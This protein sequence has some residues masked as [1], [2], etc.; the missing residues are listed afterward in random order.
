MTSKENKE[1]EEEKKHNQMS[2]AFMCAI[3]AIIGILYVVVKVLFIHGHCWVDF[4]LLILLLF[5]TAFLLLLT[6]HKSKKLCERIE[7]LQ[8]EGGDR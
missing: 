6:F 8:K 2:M 3:T 5:V 7:N 4:P 1:I